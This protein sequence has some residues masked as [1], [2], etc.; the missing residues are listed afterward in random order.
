MTGSDIAK[1][2]ISAPFFL[3][4]VGIIDVMVKEMTE[5]ARGK[6]WPRGLRWF[7]GVYLGLCRA[8]HHGCVRLLWPERRWELASARTEQLERWDREWARTL[9]WSPGEVPEWRPW[10][11][12]RGG[13]WQLRSEAHKA[14]AR[15]YR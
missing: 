5:A 2:T 12:G 10:P 1:V 7:P 13:S 11:D 9:S 15:Y 4:A 14:G 6:L 8:V 3:L